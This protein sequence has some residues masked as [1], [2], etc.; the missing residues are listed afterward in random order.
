MALGIAL[1]SELNLLRRTRLKQDKVCAWSWACWQASWDEER[2]LG[3]GGGGLH[4]GP[5]GLSIPTTPRAWC[6]SLQT[7]SILS[8]QMSSSKPVVPTLLHSFYFVV[9][10][11]LFSALIVALVSKYQEA[12]ACWRTG[13]W[14]FSF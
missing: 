14:P 11:A 9:D 12:R 10:L 4:E 3:G 8:R 7:Q 13:W 1:S 5:H 2:Q 6:R